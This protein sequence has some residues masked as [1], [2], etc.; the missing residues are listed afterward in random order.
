MQ[1]FSPNRGHSIYNGRIYLH[2]SINWEGGDD[3]GNYL[4]F[5][6]VV[7]RLSIN[8]TPFKTIRYHV[9]GSGSFDGRVNPIVVYTEVLNSNHVRLSYK[10][11]YT[12]AVSVDIFDVDVS[13]INEFVFIG[14]YGRG[15]RK[16][17]DQNPHDMYITQ[18]EF[19]T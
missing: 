19:L 17:P 14:I 2:D 16:N 7:N 10:F 1:D 6:G 3:G 11:A 4:T 8:V 9:Y 18:I 5:G 12:S 13:N 15:A